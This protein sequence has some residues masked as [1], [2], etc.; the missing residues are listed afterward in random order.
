MTLG[1][2]MSATF[3]VVLANNVRVLCFVADVM[4]SS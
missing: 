4:H 3:D 1:V 2:A